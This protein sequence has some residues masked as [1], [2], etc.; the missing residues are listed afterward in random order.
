MVARQKFVDSSSHYN[1]SYTLYAIHPITAVTVSKKWC[2]LLL[3]CRYCASRCCLWCHWSRQLS[4][5]SYYDSA[6][7]ARLSTARRSRR[8]PTRQWSTSGWWRPPA[9]AL[10]VSSRRWLAVDKPR[11]P[12]TNCS[13]SAREPTTSTKTRKTWWSSTQQLIKTTEKSSLVAQSLAYDWRL[14]WTCGSSVREYVFYVFFRFQK[15]WL[16]TFFWVVVHVFSNT[17]WINRSGSYHF[18]DRHF[19]YLHVVHPAY[20]PI[21]ENDS[22]W[23]LL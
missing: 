13:G 5:S 10:C 23:F 12:R 11:P 18:P 8:V 3:I 21:S 4:A 15:T 9:S 14:L 16:F 2:V 22:C 17:V 1:R 6:F 7:F 19:D 20:R